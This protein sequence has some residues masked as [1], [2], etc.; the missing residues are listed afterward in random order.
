MRTLTK[1]LSCLV[2][3][4][5]AATLFLA[6]CGSS[7]SREPMDRP[8]V[9]DIRVG[10]VGHD[11]Q[12]ALFVA[13]DNA[14]RFSM[15]T[16]ISLKMVEDRK[17]Y[18]LFDGKRKLANVEIVLVGGGAKMPTALAQ[19]IIDVGFGG[20]VPTLAMADKGA[21][22]KIIAP[23]HSRGD[24]LVVRPDVPA[25][26][27]REFVEYVLNSEEPV[28]IG[29]KA[30]IAVAK[31]VFEEALRHE[32]IVSSGDLSRRDVQIH[33]INVKGGGK[34]NMALSGGLVDGYVGNNPF[35]AIGLEK[36]VLKV[37]C[38]LEDLP[39][40]TLRDHPCCCIAA[41]TKALREKGEVITALLVLFLQATDLINSDLDGAVT[42][43]TRWLGTSEQVE[44]SSI[45][46]SGYSMDP[47]PEWHDR[48]AVWLKTM[49]GLAVFVGLLRE[50]T[51]E[52]V[53]GL[54]YDLSLLETAK[55]RLG[56]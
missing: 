43:A 6:G 29:Y 44:R 55:E 49:Q 31:L 12:I 2:I 17:L 21:P 33:M 38:D 35:P 41:H 42:A 32:G 1:R 16:G 40:G 7:E 28:R 47:T 11:H 45:P 19:G 14:D 25:S 18:E 56:K 48:M 26:T 27:W 36:G 53:A 15:K 24:M 39:P 46:T 37:V 9:P 22:V 8:A 30:P 20:I 10:H 5:L 23:L 51:A 4:A 3:V 54:A 34:L 50:A 52:E 13:A